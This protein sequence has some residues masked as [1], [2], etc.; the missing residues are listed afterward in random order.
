MYCILLFSKKMYFIDQQPL[1]F[2]RIDAESPQNNQNE[3]NIKYLVY[4][5][6]NHCGGW[7]DRLKGYIFNFRNHD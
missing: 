3:S 7:A 1:K 4:E 6:K 2:S 5:C